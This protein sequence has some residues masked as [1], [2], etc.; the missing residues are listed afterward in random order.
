MASAVHGGERGASSA[1]YSN[2]HAAGDGG[3]AKLL[4]RAGVAPKFDSLGSLAAFS[5]QALSAQFASFQV[6]APPCDVCGNITVR[7]G[8]CYL[9]HNCGNSMGCS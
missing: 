3:N 4:E 5:H 8:N 1:A 7:S 6:D 2:G 9:C